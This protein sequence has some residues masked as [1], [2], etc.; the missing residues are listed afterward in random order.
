MLRTLLSAG[1]SENIRLSKSSHPSTT[2]RCLAHVCAV[3]NAAANLPP[4][5]GPFRQVRRFSET[6]P[7]CGVARENPY[8]THILGTPVIRLDS[9]PLQRRSGVESKPRKLRSHFRLG[10]PSPPGVR[11]RAVALAVPPAH[12]RH[13][14][15]V[16]D[17]LERRAVPDVLVPCH[18]HADG[19]SGT[20]NHADFVRVRS[21]LSKIVKD[22]ENLW[23]IQKHCSR[24]HCEEELP[25]HSFAP[26]SGRP[27]PGRP[28][29]AP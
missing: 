12:N 18:R 29:S 16:V 6:L 11:L 27:C 5:P 21:K 17:S 9:R 4:P 26:L 3:L 1:V 22:C 28:C 14:N 23:R 20:K 24:E 7:L 19:L 10:A 8:D 25:E 13:I 2:A 15:H